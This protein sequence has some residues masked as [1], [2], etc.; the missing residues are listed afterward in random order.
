MK[1]LIEQTPKPLLLRHICSFLECQWHKSICP[2]IHWSSLV[3]RSPTGCIEPELWGWVPLK[4][5]LSS[6]CS[7]GLCQS[8]F[9]TF[10]AKVTTQNKW[11]LLWKETEGGND[12]HSRN[13]HLR[14]QSPNHQQAWNGHCSK[15]YL[16][17]GT[18]GTHVSCP[19]KNGWL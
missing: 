6:Q 12:R 18:G 16:R 15:K 14:S 5:V 2:V 10:P 7:V 4:L 11:D 13:Y 19:S 17:R 8:H 3:D 9:L 1:L